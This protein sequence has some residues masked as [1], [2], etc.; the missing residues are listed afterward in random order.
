MNSIKL[1]QSSFDIIENPDI[2]YGR[3]NA[4]FAQGFYLSAEYLF[5]MILS[6]IR[7]DQ[8][9]YIN[10]YELSL[11]DLSIKHFSRDLEW[12]KY[13]ISNRNNIVDT[14][15]DYDLIIGP[16]ANDTIFDTFGLIGSNILNID[17]FL[18][19]YK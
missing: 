9:V 5:S 11:D 18:N 8:D 14:Y 15:K 10:K 17:T 19:Y 7:K 3:K 1:Y 6:R 2:H 12:I 16:I 13:I 4:D